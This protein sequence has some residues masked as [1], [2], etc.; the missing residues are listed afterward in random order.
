MSCS[1][2]DLRDYFLQELADPQQRRQVES[3]VATCRAC[4]EELD[5]LR[6]TEAALFSLREE[7]IPQRIAFV[8]DKVF[9]PS[10]MRRWLAGLWNSSARLG[11][12]SA[13]MLSV[14]LVVFAATRPAPAPAPV[15]ATTATV[16]AAEIEQRVQAAADKAAQ[17]IEAR[18]DA[19]TTQ[20]VNS[21]RQKDLRERRLMAASFD[22]QGAYFERRLQASERDNRN[23]RGQLS[24]A[25]LGDGEGAK[26]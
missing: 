25:Q 2:F 1:P 11:F 18:Y 7:E 22:A 15:P 24:Q 5:R 23:L 26:Q 17:A 19:K 6:L 12:A 3:H 13:A 9:E 20:L 8:S 21:I 4:H 14:A 16:N 10:P